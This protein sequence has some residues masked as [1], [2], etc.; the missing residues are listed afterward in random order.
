M[1]PRASWPATCTP[2]SNSVC[3]ASFPPSDGTTRPVTTRARTAH[4]AP[5]STHLP[6]E[7]VV[8]AEGFC[9]LGAKPPLMSWTT[10]LWG[11]PVKPTFW[12]CPNS[13]RSTRDAFSTRRFLISSWGMCITKRAQVESWNSSIWRPGEATWSALWQPLV[14]TL[15]F[16]FYKVCVRKLFEVVRGIALKL[17]KK[18]NCL[19]VNTNFVAPAVKFSGFRLCHKKLW[20]YSCE[21]CRKYLH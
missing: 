4:P 16:S 2:T 10:T 9:A 1:V 12:P 19:S 21:L 17:K 6:Q 7:E 15:F 13:G 3:R 5:Q 18:N 20:I 11:A 8:E 14:S